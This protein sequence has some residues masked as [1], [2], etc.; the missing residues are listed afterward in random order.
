MGGIILVPLNKRSLL[1]AIP[2][3][4]ALAILCALSSLAVASPEWS[5]TAVVTDSFDQANPA[6]SGSIVVW[7]DYRNKQVVPPNTGTGCPGAQN[8][9]AADIYERDLAGGPEQRLTSTYNALDPDISG[10]NVVW[11]NWDTGKIVVHNLTTGDEQDTSTA[12]AQMVSPSISGNIV[13]WTDYRN[14][15]DYGDIYMRDLTQPADAPVSVA[16][17][18]PAIP[19]PTKDKRNPD[20]DGSIVA[21][22]DMRNAYQDSS[23][24]WH[25]PDIYM[26]NLTTGV[27]QAVCTDASDQYNP[28]VAGHRIYWQ[29][30]RNGNWDVYMKDIDTGVETRVTNNAAGQSWPGASGDFAV[31]KDTRDGG[32]ATYF[33]NMVA[34]LD[35]RISAP[36]PASAQKM[37]AISG[38]RVVWMD[39]RA[40]NWDI[41]AAQDTV[42]PQ[43]GAVAPSGLIVGNSPTVSAAYSDGGAG[44][45]RSS[46]AVSLDGAPLAGC[47]VTDSGVSCPAGSVPDGHHSISVNLKDLSGNVAPASGS[48]FDVDT[49]APSIAGLSPAGTGN[50]GTVTLGADYSDLVSGVNA[51]SASISLD[52]G[53]I[54]GCSASATHISCTAAVADGP[55]AFTVSV[56]DNAG[57]G[58]SAAGAFTVDTVAP[59][60]GGV[61]PNGWLASTSTVISA[62]YSDTGTGVDTESVSVSLDG[63]AVSGCTVAAGSVSCPVSGLSQG[64]HSAGISLRDVAGNP[65]AGSASF[66][67]DSQAPLVGPIAAVVAP[68]TVDAAIDADLSDP[69]PGSGVNAATVQVI[70]DGS[71]YTG[72]LVTA[73]HVSCSLTG[74]AMG[75]HT[76]TIN[77]SDNLGNAGTASKI[78]AVADSV[79]P[80]IT[81]P[82]PVG[83]ITTDSSPISA[84]YSDDFPSSGIDTGSV[85]LQLDD[86]PLAGCAAST[87]SVSCHTVGLAEGSHQVSLSLSDYAGNST[88]QAWS[89]TVQAG[90]IARGFSPA[91]GAIVNNPLAP[92]SAAWVRNGADIDAASVSVYIDGVLKASPAITL[93]GGAATGGFSFLPEWGTRFADGAHS[94]RVV[95]SDVNKRVTDQTWSFTVTSPSL[96]LSTVGV[97]WSSYANYVNRNLSVRDRLMDPGTGACQAAKIELGTA[98]NGVMLLDPLPFDVGNI[99]SGASADYIFTYLIP[100]GVT[101][102][103]AVSYASC[104]D[105]GGNTY[106]MP[107]PPPVF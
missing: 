27:E 9:T 25:N 21:W 28:V 47:T 72:C 105:D 58:G 30:F 17:P 76:I 79:A 67:M 83:T 70:L 107:G 84:A 94:V 80:V 45:D 88:S 60:I 73:S 2:V 56:A 104:Q 77:A 95:V 41:Y 49:A 85:L 87:T 15:T 43:I 75:P 24:W 40:G 32:E 37:P 86:S 34:G 26:K 74:L 93:T 106:W 44:V 7:Q 33:R 5:E 82:A 69:L 48:N 53:A 46:V 55:H 81:A 1:P 35:E 52:G 64:A 57:N 62:P 71:A 8:C 42:A 6:V 103:R 11:R 39:K 29:D 20:I 13:V 66:N 91:A 31:W 68:G 22:E 12:A 65:A 50:S 100:A 18:S 4:A 90:P 99:S 92:V 19:Y 36:N 78:F 3:L 98:S 101:R 54:P 23:G 16:D 10:N 51:G 102:F 97:Y 61:A 89:F 63:A 14:S 96:S 38:G 59:V